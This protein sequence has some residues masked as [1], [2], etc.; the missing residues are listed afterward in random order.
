MYK[1][2][3]RGIERVGTENELS[4]E[5]LDF[6]EDLFDDFSNHEKSL[7]DRRDRADDEMYG[8]I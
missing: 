5:D 6:I 7:D 1:Y 4:Q 3:K 8:E 2:T